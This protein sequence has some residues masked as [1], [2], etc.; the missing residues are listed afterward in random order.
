MLSVSCAPQKAHWLIGTWVVDVEQTR[1]AFPLNNQLEDLLI[2]AQT[3]NIVDIVI[4][5]TSITTNRKE[6]EPLVLEY[7]LKA[8][9][10]EE[11][12]VAQLSNDQERIYYQNEG[13]VWYVTPGNLPMQIFLKP[14]E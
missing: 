12:L 14:Q 3:A 4:T 11:Q 10:S 6:G 8:E 5:E 7:T 9:P 2:E 13:N 1:E